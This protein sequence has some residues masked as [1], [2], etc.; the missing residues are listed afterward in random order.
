MGENS[1]ETA[2]AKILV[3]EDESEIREL[4]S[5]LLLRQGHAVQQCSNGKEAQEYLK[6]DCYDLIVLDWMMPEMSGVDLIKSLTH[7]SKKVPVL[8]VTAKAEPHDIV[9]GLE[10]GADDYITKPFQPS[11]FTARVKALLRRLHQKSAPKENS[12]DEW[13]FGSLK[14]N[15]ASY[16][17]HCCDEKIH[18]T[19]SEFKLMAC[20]AQNQGRVMTRDQLIELIQGEGINVTGRTIDTHIFGLRKKLSDCADWI[21]TIRGVGYRI[22]TEVL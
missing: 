8:M 11:V 12:K 15:M 18:L 16:E 14:V 22:R 10:A 9:T 3:V 2:S 17:V 6:K 20:M 1:L 13:I 4:I 7:E 5:L 21:E 19:P